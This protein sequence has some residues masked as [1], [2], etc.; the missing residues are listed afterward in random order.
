MFRLKSSSEKEEVIV[1]I[2]TGSFVRLLLITAVTVLLFLAIKQAEHALVLIL[3]AFFLTIALNTPV[4]WLSRHLP[5][6][7]KNSR[8]LATTLSFLAVVIIIGGII[9]IVAP[10]LVKQ[11]NDLIKTAPHLI[12]E[13]RDQNSPV[14]KFIRE[15]HLQNE[16]SNLSKQISKVEGHIGG[17]ALGTAQHIADSLISLLTILVLTFMMLVEMPRW[18]RVFKEIV[19]SR[20]HETSERVA[21]DM[22]LVIRGYV[23][24][25]VLLAALASVVIMPAVL[26]LHIGYPAGIVLVIFICGLIPIIGHTIGAVIVTIFA[27][28]H[29]TSAAVIILAYYIV[30]MQIE[31]YIIQPKIQANTTNMSPLLVFMAVVIGLS[32]GGILG[33]LL[34]I[35]IAGCMRVAVLE[36]LRS[37][38]IINE[39]TFKKVTTL[40]SK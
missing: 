21:H 34:A 25:Q 38:N 36:L 17:T 39:H 18:V 12:N 24:G 40:D 6:P 13:F 15:H 3:I 14:G 4:Y 28:F 20:H 23:N 22:F 1:S 30:Y 32:F 16:V 19:P 8:S 29:S 5:G 37:R 10:P 2:S 33:G 31:A 9:T 27:L 26:L 7:T 11:T 35:P